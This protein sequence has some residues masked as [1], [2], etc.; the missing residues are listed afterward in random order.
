MIGIANSANEVIPGHLH[1]HQI[2]SAVKAGVRM[3]GGTPLEFFTI[4]S[5]MVLSWDTKG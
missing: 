5:A 4:G 1:L 3:A 2:S